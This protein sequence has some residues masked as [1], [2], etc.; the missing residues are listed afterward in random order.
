MKVFQNGQIITEVEGWDR[1]LQ[2]GDGLFE[3][4]RIANAKPVAL[5]YHGA[6]LNAGMSRL[7]F[8]TESEAKRIIIDTLAALL[9]DTSEG[10]L[11]LI[12]T[13]GDSARGYR[14]PEQ[15]DINVTAFFSALPSYPDEYYAAGIKIGF[16]Q[17]QAAIQTQLAGLKH[18]NRL[19]CV[20]AASEVANKNGEWQ[21]GLMVNDLGFVIE[22]TMS[23]VF[24]K[25]GNEWVTPKLDRSGVAGTM[26]QRILNNSSLD[27]LVRDVAKSEVAN[28]SAMFVCNSLIGIW[29]VA[30]FEGKKLAVPNEITSLINQWQSAE[31]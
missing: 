15:S 5:D 12:V 2:F 16:C 26:R 14:P 17:T 30:E 19:D 27:V 22:G 13:R 10:V 1:G 4:I 23:N 25:I 20:L 9:G 18:L 7:G 11:K 28:V 6:R 8:R 31:L 24:A 29:P 21:E 3:T